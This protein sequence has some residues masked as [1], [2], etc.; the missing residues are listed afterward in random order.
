MRY[1]RLDPDDVVF[2]RQV[3]VYRQAQREE[4]EL[5]RLEEQERNEAYAARMQSMYGANIPSNPPI[6]VSGSNNWAGVDAQENP[7]YSWW[8][9]VKSYTAMFMERVKDGVEWVKEFLSTLSSDERW[10][11]M[12][13]ID[14]A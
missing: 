8:R 3:L 1:Y 11:V 4:R 7:T 6:N 9:Q 10:G 13:A 12:V 2:T 5:R 14:E